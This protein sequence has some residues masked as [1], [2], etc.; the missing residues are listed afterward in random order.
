MNPF[1]KEEGLFAVVVVVND[2]VFRSVR[3]EGDELG[4][5][6]LGTQTNAPSNADRELTD[7]RDEIVAQNLQKDP[8]NSGNLQTL[9]SQPASPP[10]LPW[11]A[12]VSLTAE[13]DQ[14]IW[15]ARDFKEMENI[16]LA[17]APNEALI[18]FHEDKPDNIDTLTLNQIRDIA[19]TIPDV[20]FLVSTEEDAN[21]LGAGAG[22][23][24]A[25]AD[26]DG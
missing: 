12:I 19:P 23:Y 20:V 21:N 25:A 15:I 3:G 7:L 11:I 17:G 1:V 2:T 22:D 18:I 24:G 26:L 8:G 6:Y 14:H 9:F 13:A 16:A 5:L 10:D 4:V